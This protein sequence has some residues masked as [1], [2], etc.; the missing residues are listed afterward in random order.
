ML[1][2]LKRKPS[3]LKNLKRKIYRIQL[4]DILAK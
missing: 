3:S 4:L 2:A 1:S